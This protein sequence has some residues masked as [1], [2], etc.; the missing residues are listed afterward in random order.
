LIFGGP[1]GTDNPTL[2]SDG[3]PT[4]DVAFLNTFPYMAGPF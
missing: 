2:T 4:N 1:G 3:V